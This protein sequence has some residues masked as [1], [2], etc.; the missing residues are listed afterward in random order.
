MGLTDAQM[1][2]VP[3]ITPRIREALGSIKEA[4]QLIAGDDAPDSIRF[5]AKWNTLPPSDQKRCPLE[6]VITA[7]G[8][9]PRRFMELLGGITFEYSATA[10]KMFVA[11]NQLKV[12]KSTVKAATDELPITAYD[13]ESGEVK[14]VGH[15][16]GDVKAMEIF[17]K[18][19]GALPTP[20]G[21]NFIINP[22]ASHA[23]GHRARLRFSRWIQCCWSLRTFRKPRPTP[24]RA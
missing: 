15:T 5:M 11:R 4:I 12:M 10:T 20:K 22:D 19:T 9:T 17:H 23:S 3:S 7:A 8:L 6:E 1:E 13:A 24:M 14:V 21:S 2:G 18:I 16:N